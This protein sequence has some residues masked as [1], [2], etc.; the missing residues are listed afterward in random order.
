LLIGSLAKTPHPLIEE[1]RLTTRGKLIFMCNGRRQS[2]ALSLKKGAAL[3]GGTGPRRP[4]ETG[5]S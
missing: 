5:E 1:R 4:E 3:M 2:S